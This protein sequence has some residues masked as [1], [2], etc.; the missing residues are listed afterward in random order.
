[1]IPLVV[2][3]LDGTV[4]DSKNQTPG[5]VWQMAEKLQT[6]GIQLAVATGRPRVGAAKRIAEAFGPSSPHIFQ[7]GALIAYPDGQVVKL[8]VLKEAQ[9][10]M[11]VNHARA[12]NLMLELYT[13]TSLYVERTTPLGSRHS[14]L[15]GASP[16]VRNLEEVASNEPVVRAQWVIPDDKVHLA[17]ELNLTGVQ[18]S[19]NTSPVLP[20]ITFISITAQN[21][22]KGSAIKVLAENQKV[23]LKDVMAVGD[24]LGDLSM[25]EQVGHPIVMGNAPESMQERFPTVSHV[26]DCGAAEA[27]EQALKLRVQTT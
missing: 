7:S 11:L 25:L 10:K 3:D 17:Q 22:S 16:I 2:L 4:I 19:C 5:C 26:D 21:V 14:E 23:N 13:A 15:I 6:A 20:G 24:S 27:M 8:Q 1:M 12:K 9:A 18:A